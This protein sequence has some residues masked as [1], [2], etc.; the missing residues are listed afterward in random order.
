[1]RNRAKCKKCGDIIESKSQ[2]DMVSCSCGEISIDGGSEHFRC[3]AIDWSN[4]LRVAD[5][6]SEI[7][8]KIA[9]KEDKQEKERI[10]DD[11]KEDRISRSQL[12]KILEDHIRHSEGLPSYVKTSFVTYMDLDAVVSLIIG[13][14]KAKD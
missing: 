3:L 9:D 4:F 11:I 12:I 6:G 5:D 14:I 8:V 1:M 13:I 7:E 10:D 2:N